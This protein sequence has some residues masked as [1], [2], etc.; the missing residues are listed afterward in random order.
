VTYGQHGTD[1]AAAA[2]IETL[3]SRDLTIGTAESLTGGMV[4]V[5]LTSVPGASAVFRGGIVAYAADLKSALLAVPADLIAE[6][7]TVHEDIAVAMAQGARTALGATIGVGTT[8]VAGPDPSEGH[9]VGT[10]HIAVAV[11]GRAR[12]QALSLAGG[13][14]QI[15]YGTVQRVLLLLKG[16]LV[17][18]LA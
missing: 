1:S 2:V 3:I 13:R 6:V 14:D 17:E 12:H 15:R 9:P 4:A 7:G 16:M 11:P 8:G 18:D 5:A 10:A